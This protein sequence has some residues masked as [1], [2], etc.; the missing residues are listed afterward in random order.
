MSNKS[1][2]PRTN[3]PAA[4]K[5]PA[6]RLEKQVPFNQ[7]PGNELLVP[8]D[9]LSAEKAID[10]VVDF[11]FSGEGDFSMKEVQQLIST[12]RTGGF[13]KD[14]EGFNRFATAK[15][16]GAVI[17]LATAYITEMLKDFA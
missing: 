11:D 15:N 13:V 14:E 12:L 6:D 4:A 5:A 3:V 2:K 10:L 17:N 16:L 9:E 1:R 7:V 8:L